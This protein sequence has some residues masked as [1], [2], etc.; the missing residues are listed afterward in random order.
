MA[1]IYATLFWCA[2]QVSIFLALALPIYLIVR[3]RNSSAGA[4]TAASSLAAVVLLSFLA[5][6]P[7]PRWS[8]DGFRHSPRSTAPPAGRESAD[9]SSTPQLPSPTAAATLSP[10]AA[11]WEAM[12]LKDP[13]DGTPTPEQ[14]THPESRSWA[15]WIVSILL[16]GMLLGLAHLAISLLAV[17]RLI[18]RSQPLID[19]ALLAELNALR[20]QLGITRPVTL[21]VSQEIA[22][23]ATVGTRRPVLLLPSNWQSWSL[24][25]RRAV[26]AHE[27][28]HI[29]GRD[30]AAWL[31]ARAAIV[32]HFYHPLVRWFVARLQLDQEL[33]ADA[34]AARL[35]GDRN[36]YLHALA[37]LA[38]ATPPQR[39]GGLVRTFIPGRSLLVR[40]VE[41][42]R[43]NQRDG[44]RSTPSSIGRWA[45]MPLLAALAVVAAGLRAPDDSSLQAAEPE[46][47]AAEPAAPRGSSGYEFAYIP[48]DFVFLIAIRPSEIAA[49]PQLKPLAE[50]MNETLRPK[51]KFEELEQ[52]TF[53]VPAPMSDERGAT[54]PGTGSEYTIFRTA[55]ANVDFKPLIEASYGAVRTEDY[56]GKQLL[57]W[58][59]PPG[60]GTIEFYSPVAG[61]L[62]STP[63]A[64]LTPVIDDPKSAEPPAAAVQWMAEAKGPMFGVVNISALK[65]VFSGRSAAPFLPMFQPIFDLADHAT[66]SVE[67]GD[68][69]TFKASFACRNAEDA[70]RVE[71]TLQAGL[72]IV[73]NVIAAQRTQLSNAAPASRSDL[74]P[75]FDIADQLIA[76]VKTTVNA[77]R[78]EMTAF[79]KNPSEALR[80]ALIPQLRVSRQAA[81]RNEAMNSL[82]QLGLA[83]HLYETKARSFPP[84]VFY[85]KSS[86]GDLNKSGDNAADVPRSWRVELLPF[87]GQEELYKQYR[88]DQPWD[89][90]ANLAVLRKMPDVFR[91]PNDKPASTNASYFAIAGPGTVF[92]GKEGT[93]VAEIRDGLSNTLLLVEA[94]RDIPWTKPEDIAYAADQPVPALGGWRPSEFLVTMCDG[95]VHPVY[96][97]QGIDKNF[98][99]PW[100]GKADGQVPPPLWTPAPA[101]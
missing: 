14:S 89:S 91:S 33:A 31:I 9:S 72:V 96:N 50:L 42:L 23:P 32:L 40:R 2:L 38:L 20:S 15:T 62:I 26:L 98:L 35:L 46:V 24:F 18:A 34:T 74:L 5:V 4:A 95:S 73:K 84:S 43:T 22:T 92:D 52:M 100:I 21:C 88:L 1:A 17:R 69:L 37:N 19:P 36:E 30:F 10:L 83:A 25:E 12:Q 97:A 7:W 79:V 70:V 87:L 71:Q 82:K 63:R 93:P 59:N 27:L 57:V 67:D 28:A 48:K 16:A 53:I 64:Q 78:V 60:Q 85:G 51:F 45:L 76:S 11:M 39:G 75:L 61:T 49:S 80:Q 56:K 90:E 6:S 55:A 58:G 8:L 86:H 65:M 77:G 3:R 13:I 44:L 41:M 99:R 94:K 101:P 47:A 54:I 29:A 81:A 66:I 68:P